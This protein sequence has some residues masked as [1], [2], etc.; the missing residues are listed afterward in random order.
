[1]SKTGKET[2]KK[3]LGNLPLCHPEISYLADRSH[4][5]RGYGS[6]MFGLAVAAKAVSTMKKNGRKTPPA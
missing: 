6:K 2:K 5:I 3:C 4:R 1:M